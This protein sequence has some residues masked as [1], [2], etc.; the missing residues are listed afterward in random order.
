MTVRVTVCWPAVLYAIVGL[1]A[2]DEEGVPP[3]KVQSMSPPP[4]VKFVNSTSKGIQPVGGL[5]LNC[6]MGCANTW[7]VS[8]P[9]N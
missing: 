8:V 3:A 5:V 4:V 2:V 6:V 1:A 9:C 7:M